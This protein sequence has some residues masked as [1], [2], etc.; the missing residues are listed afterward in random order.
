M[1]VASG[2][3]ETG[4]AFAGR[5]WP[6]NGR[7]VRAK[8]SV[9]TNVCGKELAEVSV[10]SSRGSD[11]PALVSSVSGKVVGRCC[12]AAVAPSARKN[13][14]SRS[15]LWAKPRKN[16][17]SRRKKADFGVFCVRWANFFARGR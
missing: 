7:F 1:G 16:S 10:V 3:G 9:V 14:P 12:E 15:G 13:S 5:K 6:E 2:E 17:P 4:D 8:V 11:P